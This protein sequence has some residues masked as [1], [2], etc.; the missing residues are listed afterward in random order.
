VEQIPLELQ[1]STYSHER[2]LSV[3]LIMGSARALRIKRWMAVHQEP[4]SVIPVPKLHFDKPPA[5]HAAAHGMRSWIP[6]IEIAHQINRLR[7]R[8]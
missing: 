5:I 6:S 1:I 2:S 8:S 4:I 3:V 7:R